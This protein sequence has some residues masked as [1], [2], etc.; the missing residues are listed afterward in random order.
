MEMYNGVE[1]ISNIG[2]FGRCTLCLETYVNHH[3]ECACGE[4]H[5]FNYDS[6][7]ICQGVWKLILEC[8]NNREYITCVKLKSKFLGIG[9]SGFESLFG[10]KL[11][12]I[13]ENDIESD[14]KKI[15]SN[16]T[17]IPDKIANSL[18]SF[19]F[20]I[21]KHIEEMEN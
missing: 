5:T 7:I 14:M 20:I 15:E 19:H 1:F 17:N 4:V 9:F 11:V 21:K 18:F 13:S 6:N 10:T 2:G 16:P 12:V 3:Y 8:P